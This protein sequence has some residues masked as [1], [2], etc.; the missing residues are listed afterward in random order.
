LSDDGHSRADK[1]QTMTQSL[2][3]FL[4][5]VY[6]FEVTTRYRVLIRAAESTPKQKQFIY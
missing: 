6:H 4:W 3:Y 1:R 2:Y 5:R